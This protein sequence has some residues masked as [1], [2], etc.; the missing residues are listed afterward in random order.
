M[1]NTDQKF[2]TDQKKKIKTA[3]MWIENSGGGGGELPAYKMPGPSLIHL[4][5][6]RKLY[7]KTERF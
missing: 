1:Q 6:K 3:E 7:F 4:T 5:R 2:L